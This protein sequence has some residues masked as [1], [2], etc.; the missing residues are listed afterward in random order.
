MKLP[1]NSP[2]SKLFLLLL[3]S[4][5]TALFFVMTGSQFAGSVYSERH[6][7]KSL[8]RA[9][10]LQPYN[11]EYQYRLGLYLSLLQP[12]AA[13]K[14][15]RGAVALNP[16]R[17]RYWTALARTDESLADTKSQSLA[18][19]TAALMAPTDPDT[20]WEVANAYFSQRNT[21]QALNQCRTLLRDDG[22]MLGNALPF[23]WR[24]KPDADLF[25]RDLLPP[26]N[27]DYEDLLNL[28]ISKRDTDSSAK[29][30]QG[31]INLHG[32]ISQRQVFDYM[33]FLLEQHQPESAMN[34]WKQAA[35][36]ANLTD[37]QPS[38][39]NL[40][41]NGNF[42]LPILNGGFDWFYHKNNNVTLSLDTEQ[43]YSADRSLLISF[44]G[45]QIEDA[46][47]GQMVPVDPSGT[48]NF[49]AYYKA[50]QMEGAG[51]V[52]FAVQDAYAGTVL[53]A[54]KYLANTSDWEQLNGS[55]TAGPATKLLLVRIQRDPAGDVIKGKLWID[56]VRLAKQ[57]PQQP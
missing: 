29:I 55:F 6:D 53:F 47:I 38:P 17:A 37:Y 3:S 7:L 13:V 54:S 5:L 2:A 9:V 48:Y 39:A 56:G 14:S 45:A 25:M 30:W 31:L 28:L 23:C 46:G 32:P 49:S 22:P 35:R 11:A 4:L 43:N 41:V 1:L 18:L 16:Y 36:F 21:E 50:Q 19:Q 40:M 20:I 51:G 10:L 26:K 15:F 8:Q 24:V 27:V 57:T 12:D 42:S 34:A 44:D 52:R 33:R